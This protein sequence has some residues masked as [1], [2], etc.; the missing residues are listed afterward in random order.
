MSKAYGFSDKFIELVWTI[1]IDKDD[2]E[3]ADERKAYKSRDKHAICITKLLT[4]GAKKDGECFVRENYNIL[5]IDRSFGLIL[6]QQSLLGSV[7]AY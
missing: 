4:V 7:E 3:D 6:I 1:I 5:T 2:S